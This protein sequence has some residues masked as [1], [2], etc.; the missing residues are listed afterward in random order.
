MV[1]STQ[2]ASFIL[3]ILC[4]TRARED[5]IKAVAWSHGIYKVI[6]QMPSTSASGL[7]CSEVYITMKVLKVLL[8]ACVIA[9]IQ[10]VEAQYIPGKQ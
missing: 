6:L 9:A 8:L 5:H 2:T 10:V 7:L 1:H 3:I 4:K